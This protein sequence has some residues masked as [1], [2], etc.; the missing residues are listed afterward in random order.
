MNY[1]VFISSLGKTDGPSS[2]LRVLPSTEIANLENNIKKSPLFDGK[3]FHFVSL[4]KTV[5]NG[6]YKERITARCAK[7]SVL[8]RVT[9]SSRTNLIRHMKVI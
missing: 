5:T 1:L 3:Y 7:C 6:K 4:E 9:N 2:L 8:I